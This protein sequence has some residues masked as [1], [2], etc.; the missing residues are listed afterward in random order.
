MAEEEARPSCGSALA[1][2]IAAM[3]CRRRGQV[4]VVVWK[5]RKVPAM[6]MLTKMND[7]YAKVGPSVRHQPTYPLAATRHLSTTAG[8]GSVTARRARPD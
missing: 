1:D 3:A 5:T 2:L 4:R 6:D 7:L 8:P